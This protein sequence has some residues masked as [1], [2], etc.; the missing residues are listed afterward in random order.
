[1]FPAEA[2]EGAQFTIRSVDLK[3]SIS[4]DAALRS[5]LSGSLRDLARACLGWMRELAPYPYY[6]VDLA[7]DGSNTATYGPVSAEVASQVVM[8]GELVSSTQPMTLAALREAGASAACLGAIQA[9]LLLAFWQSDPRFRRTLA[10]DSHAIPCYVSLISLRTETPYEEIAPAIV[11]EGF[12]GQKWRPRRKP[13]DRDAIREIVRD[14]EQLR[15]LVGEEHLLILEA[16]QSFTPA[17]LALFVNELGKSDAVT[18][19]FWIE[20]PVGDSKCLPTNVMPFVA[21]GERLTGW[22][23]VE[24]FRGAA[25]LQPDFVMAGGVRPMQEVRGVCD[26]DGITYAPH[27]RHL[28]P[29]LLMALGGC[30]R[31]L[32]EYNLLLEPQR[33]AASGRIVQPVAGRLGTQG[34]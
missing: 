12:A 28:E 29:A 5:L 2:L 4:V 10:T 33:Q 22:A 11:A 20:D 9:A 34:I 27:G 19:P 32:L 30:G 1:M 6:V 17:S 3:A 7:L 16:G 24:E 14:C 8:V 21:G 18:G 26:R 15:A 13:S 31:R 23:I 25:A